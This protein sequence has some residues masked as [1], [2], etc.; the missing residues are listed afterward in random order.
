MMIHTTGLSVFR[1][2]IS[3]ANQSGRTPLSTLTP[4][5]ALPLSTASNET[6]AAC[7]IALKVAVKISELGPPLLLLRRLDRCERRMVLPL[8]RRQRCPCRFQLPRYLRRHD[9]VPRLPHRHLLQMDHPGAQ[10][11]RFLLPAHQRL[12][13]I[14]RCRRRLAAIPCR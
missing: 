11:V 13:A 14:R 9:L 3:P 2:Q 12:P 5:S 1:L 4:L 6:A 7:P 10:L 8:G